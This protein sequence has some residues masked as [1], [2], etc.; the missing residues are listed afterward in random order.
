MS[1]EINWSIVCLLIKRTLA[2]LK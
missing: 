1:T 2:V